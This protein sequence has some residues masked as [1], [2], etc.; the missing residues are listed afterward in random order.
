MSLGIAAGI[1]RNAAIGAYGISLKSHGSDPPTPKASAKSSMVFRMVGGSSESRAPKE[2]PQNKSPA[3]GVLI[4][5]TH[6]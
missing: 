6:T 5:V 4:D 3:T 2:A 1:S